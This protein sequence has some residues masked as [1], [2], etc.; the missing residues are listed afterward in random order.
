VVAGS[1]SADDDG[2]MVG[3]GLEFRILGPL[4]VRRDGIVVPLGGARPRALLAALLRNSNRVVST[5]RLIDELWAERPPRTARTALQGY[6]AQ[7]RRAL[8]DGSDQV[9]V[10]EASG[11]RLRVT[12]GH[13]D[14]DRFE[15]LVEEARK[16]VETGDHGSAC[17]R[18]R[19]ALSLW[20]GPVLADLQCAASAAGE[21][22]GVEELRL[23]VLG[24]RIEAEL[25]VGRDAELVG[26]LR[27]LVGAHPLRERFH[28]QLMLALYRSGR[29]AEALEAYRDAR[30]VLVEELGIEPGPELRALERAILD[31]DPA[32]RVAESGKSGSG[33]SVHV[34]PPA[35]A[36]SL[37]P[38]MPL[39]GREREIGEL[40]ELQQRAD[41]RL[42]TLT[43]PGGIG[44]T[45]LALAVL[46]RFEKRFRDG[47]D[48][49]LL[50]GVR[51]PEL[52]VLAIARAL[53]VDE[54]G[55]EPI[56]DRLE[57]FLAG[58]EL[59]LLLDNFE[60]VLD[61][62]PVVAR[63]LGRAPGLT[64]LVTSRAL[65]H[66]SGEH[67][68]VVPPL[69]LPDTTQIAV[70]D[71]L[72][73]SEA[74]SLFVQ[75]ATALQP[76]FTLDED[77]ARVV[78]DICARVEGV[79]LALELAAART[80]LLT[81]TMLLDR[82][83][84]RLPMLTGGA[85][86]LPARQ[87]T[88]R[89]TLDW[90]YE[91]LDEP[92]RRLFARLSVFAGGFTEEA[93]IAVSGEVGGGDDLLDGLGA[94]VDHSLL[95]HRA[96]AG[97]GERF[98][99]LE[100]IR[101]YALQQLDANGPAERVRRRHAE[102]FLALV[103]R[104]DDLLKGPQQAV[105][106]A[107]LHSEQENLRAALDWALAADP[108]L[109]LTL[110]GALRRFWLYG[111]HCR[112]AERW[113]RR[114]LATAGPPVPTVSYVR[115]LLG[116]ATVADE[117]GDY[118]RAAVAAEQ[119]L[120]LCRQVGD[121]KLL[122]SC[123]NLRANQATELGD[124][125]EARRG[126]KECAAIAQRLGDKWLLMLATNNLGY[127]ALTEHEYERAVDLC[128]EG[129]AVAEH[130]GDRHQLSIT[131]CNLAQAL[132]H[133]GREEEAL[134]CLGEA[135]RNARAA[136]DRVT[137]MTCLAVAGAAFM[138]AGEIERSARLLAHVEILAAD[139]GRTLE[140]AERELQDRALAVI[141]ERLSE[142]TVAAAWA[143]GR[144]M[145]LDQALAAVLERCDGRRL[146]S[147]TPTGVK[148]VGR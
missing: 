36:A 2:M 132:L 68:F 53:G 102:H 29:Q 127:L 61:A 59:L 30:R 120:S 50:A 34:R 8:R 108:P 43:G 126:Y 121:E 64:M 114:A 32:L 119:A 99:Q 86:D 72:A 76:S 70:P 11:Y 23:L 25:A 37:I 33:S 91:L 128:R 82:L 12:S 113:L 18:F 17:E 16:L 46:D 101:E 9:L 62:A 107:R 21:S 90:S 116:V 134:P 45:R 124:Y 137:G 125:E 111:G 5:D 109:A 136:G 93:A 148:P 48:A 138:L 27:E 144:A 100:I 142:P 135:V 14:L 147:F 19:D 84:K 106:L 47:G 123:C 95:D 22:E 146:R 88:L 71:S 139:T 35:L 31:H 39:I 115:A 28:G 56:L 10:T 69:G 40:G 67:V 141:R 97:G 6:I 57:R 79:P 140:T 118:T 1:R 80:R 96:G 112:E 83:G 44:K 81:P 89:A 63:L 130:L 94:L 20:R 51:D 110:A 105:W 122:A 54:H 129:I 60:Q 85:R 117:Q 78:A 75:R 103:E 74:V 58:R 65:L 98:G 4:E 42:L 87:Q 73:E 55:S 92:T 145:S 13:L 133:T 7:L 38:L 49:V 41:V 66:L 104:A 143:E 26:E 131:W 15:R 24:E 77:N 3:P 52:V